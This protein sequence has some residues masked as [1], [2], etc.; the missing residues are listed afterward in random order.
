LPVEGGSLSQTGVAGIVAMSS[1]G[2]FRAAPVL[3]TA[4]VARTPKV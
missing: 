3:P 4:S 2:T 1:Y